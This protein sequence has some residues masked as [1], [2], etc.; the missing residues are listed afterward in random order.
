VFSNTAGNNIY[1]DNVEFFV[2]NNPFPIDIDEPF[3]LYPNPSP[4]QDVR[5]TFNLDTREDLVLDITSSTGTQVFS[6]QLTHV[7]N[8]TF[9][10]SLPSLATG[11]YVVRAYTPTKVYYRKLLIIP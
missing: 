7:L 3:A 5:V 8:Q 2:S 11:V 9:Y 4:G 10:L 1:I 6:R